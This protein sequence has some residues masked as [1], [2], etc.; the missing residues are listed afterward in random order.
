MCSAPDPGR[1]ASRPGLYGGG[2]ATRDH[3]TSSHRT[4]F[5][6]VG[7]DVGWDGRRH[8][9]AA[10]HHAFEEAARHGAGLLV[11]YVWRP[12][13]LGVLDERATLRECRRLLSDMVAG[14]RVTHPG[15]D[16]HHAVLRGHPARVLARESAQA[17]ALVVGARGHGRATGPLRGS[18]A[19]GALRHTRCPVIAVPPSAACAHTHG[20]P[21]VNRLSRW[22]R[23]AAGRHIRLAARLV[24]AQPGRA[25]RGIRAGGRGRPRRA[26]TASARPAGV[27]LSPVRELPSLRAGTSPPAESTR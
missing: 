4:P 5:F 11:L 23:A 10:V 9:A 12:P 21:V 22:A 26:I 6:V 18:V 14:W 17:L 1:T 25:V 20:R 27:A 19:S 15:V 2:D 8:C 16:V 7:V 13:P 3:D 24:R